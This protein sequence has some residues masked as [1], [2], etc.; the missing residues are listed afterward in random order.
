MPRDKKC[1]VLI[2]EDEAMISMLIEDMVLDLGSEI[3]GPAS[4]IHQAMALAQVEAL[5]AAFST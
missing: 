2:V 4:K 1:R 5:D 3:V